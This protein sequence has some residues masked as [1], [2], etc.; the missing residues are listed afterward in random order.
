MKNNQLLIFFSIVLTIYSLANI[1]IYF[2]G[3]NAIPNLKNHNILYAICF[4]FVAIIFIG[5]K[6][7]ESRHSSVITDI[8]NIIGGFW[9]AFLLYGFFLFLISDII[10]LALKITGTIEKENIGLFRKISFY[11]TII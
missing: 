3:Y 9:L 11:S 7:L 10:L 8:L 6:I 5:A 2:K 1:Y 4:F